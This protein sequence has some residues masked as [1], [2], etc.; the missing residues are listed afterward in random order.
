MDRYKVGYKWRSHKLRLDGSW[1]NVLLSLSTQS[2]I[3]STCLWTMVIST[4]FSN[5]LLFLLFLKI[6]LRQWA[7]F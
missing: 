4:H 2:P 1:K 7:T 6:H 3:L 5:S